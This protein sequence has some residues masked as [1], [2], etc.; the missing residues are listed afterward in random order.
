VRLRQELLA[1]HKADSQVALSELAELKEGA[2]E[3][4]RGKWEE[5]REKLL[6]QVHVSVIGWLLFVYFLFV[7]CLARCQS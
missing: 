6:K 1:R 3:K 5:E 2:L 4:A 7:V